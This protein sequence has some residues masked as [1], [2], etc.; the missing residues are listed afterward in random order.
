MKKIV[1]I[2]DSVRKGYDRYV[3]M[4]FEGVARVYYPEENCRFAS[5]VI[6]MIDN[7]KTEMN[8][9]DDVDLVHFN[10][11]LWEDLILIDGKHHTPLSEYGEHIDRLCGMFKILFPKAKLFFAT[12]TPVL[13][14]PIRFNSDT[15]KYNALAARIVKSHGG[16]INDL[17]A[18]AN[19]CPP[20]YFSDNTHM[21]T[22]KGT[23]L[24]AS[25]VIR[26]LEGAL[27]IQAKPLDYRE[28]FVDPLSV[29]G[30]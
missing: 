13:D 12:S 14:H 28:V 23:E 2:G 8:C 30:T 16:E 11:G 21:Y 7:W 27:D 26:M 15:E 5:Y 4:A 18:V 20:E 25:A 1:L 24:L 3:K 19:G 17:Y 9:G 6:R 22:V 29:I 10:A